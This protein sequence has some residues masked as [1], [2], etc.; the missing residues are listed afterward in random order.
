MHV[1]VLVDTSILVR[2]ANTLDPMRPTTRNAI[3]KLRASG[4]VLHVAPQ[5][6]IEFRSVATRPTAVNGLGFDTAT[7]KQ[8]IDDFEL[9]FSLLPETNA[10]YPAWKGIVASGAVIGKQVH[11]ARLIAVCQTCGINR[12]I[13][14]NLN[15]FSRFA[16]L[17]PGLT[18]LDPANV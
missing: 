6:L 3:R 17:V 4:E 7:V 11:D 10:I 2:I 16:S 13:T 15:H 14:F 5:N 12:V 8:Q 9:T 1:P 18:V